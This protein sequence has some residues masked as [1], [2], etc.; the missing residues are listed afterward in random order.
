MTLIAIVC[1]ALIVKGLLMVSDKVYYVNNDNNV[2]G[3]GGEW[4][5]DP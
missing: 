3:M 5:Y 1:K 2:E 4:G